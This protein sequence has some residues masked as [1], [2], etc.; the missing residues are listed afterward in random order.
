MDSTSKSPTVAAGFGLGLGVLLFWSNALPQAW[1]KD[2]LLSNLPVGERLQQLIQ[3]HHDQLSYLWLNRV[4]VL[5]LFAGTAALSYLACSF[6][7][8]TIAARRKDESAS[9]SP[10]NFDIQHYGIDSP[11]I[12]HLDSLLWCCN[13]YNKE[14][15]WADIAYFNISLVT[16]PSQSMVEDKQ[17]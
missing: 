5:L 4:S 11:A 15:L 10:E 13:E 2:L 17:D 6:I 14:Q 7:L 1:V 12:R 8:K 3:D 16:K 9:T